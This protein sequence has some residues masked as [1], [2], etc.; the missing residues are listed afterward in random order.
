MSNVSRQWTT[1]VATAALAVGV[2]LATP[3]SPVAAQTLAAGALAPDF[4]RTDVAGQSVRLSNYRG[5]VVLLTFWAT[6]CPPC[7]D[8]IPAFSV[9]QQKYGA[10]G[11]QVLAISMDESS[12]PVKSA[13]GKYHVNYPVVMSDEKLVELYGGV[14]GLPLNFVIDPSGRIVARHQGKTNLKA[15]EDQIKSLLP[16]PR[17]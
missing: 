15:M 8:E 11:L 4:T 17:K 7:L 6:W 2:G 9:W 10:S 14:L 13:I 5:K 12:A 3:V 1:V 16:G